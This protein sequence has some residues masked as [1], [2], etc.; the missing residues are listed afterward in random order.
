MSISNGFR[1]ATQ[2]LEKER[3]TLH[4]VKCDR[5]RVDKQKVSQ[6]REDVEISKADCF[7]CDPIARVWPT[8]CGRCLKKGFSCSPGRRVPRKSKHMT[9]Q[10]TSLKDEINENEK[11][12]SPQNRFDDWYVT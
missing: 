5:C 6:V 3:R 4:L 10:P 2:Q 8:K 1:S 9:E 7:Q 11:E 12:E